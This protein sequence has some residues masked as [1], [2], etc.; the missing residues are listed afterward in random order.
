[1]LMLWVLVRRGKGEVSVIYYYVIEV[2]DMNGRTY[3]LTAI[4]FALRSDTGS[5][6]YPLNACCEGAKH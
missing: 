6:R 3:S 1:M 5:T 2:E 4:I